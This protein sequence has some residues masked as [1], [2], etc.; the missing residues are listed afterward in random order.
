MYLTV[1]I[2]VK[3]I[4]GL[5]QTLKLQFGACFPSITPR[6]RFSRAHFVGVKI[7]SLTWIIQLVLDDLVKISCF[8]RINWVYV[9]RDLSRHAENKL[10]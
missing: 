1:F 3:S 6:S 2:L 5:D 10:Q 4:R 9:N 7:K 8:N